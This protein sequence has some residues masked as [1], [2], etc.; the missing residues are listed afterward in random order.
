MVQ[1]KKRPLEASEWWDGLYSAWCIGNN[2]GTTNRVSAIV[3]PASNTSARPLG[4]VSGTKTGVQA[5]AS[6]KQHQQYGLTT[7][8]YT[9]QDYTRPAA[10]KPRDF[11]HYADVSPYIRRA[12]VELTDYTPVASFE[13]EGQ[14]LEILKDGRMWQTTAGGVIAKIPMDDKTFRLRTVGPEAQASLLSPRLLEWDRGLMPPASVILAWRNRLFTLC[15]GEAYLVIC[16]HREDKTKW[17]GVLPSQEASS[18]GVDTE[19]LDPSYAKAYEMGYESIGSTLHLHPG[20]MLCASSV[21]TDEWKKSGG[22]YFIAPRTLDKISVHVSVRNYVW[23]SVETIDLTGKPDDGTLSMLVGEEGQTTDKELAALIKPYRAVTHVAAS[24]T[25]WHGGTNYNSGNSYYC[26]GE[27]TSWGAA[28]ARS[29]MAVNA[30]EPQCL[31]D[32]KVVPPAKPTFPLLDFCEEE[33]AGKRADKWKEKLSRREEKK[34]KKAQKKAE[35]ASGKAYSAFEPAPHLPESEKAGMLKALINLVTAGQPADAQVGIVIEV[36]PSEKHPYVRFVKRVVSRQLAEKLVAAF[37]CG[38]VSIDSDILSADECKEES[39]AAMSA[40]EAKKL[41]DTRR[42]D[43]AQSAA[44]PSEADP[45]ME[46][47]H[48]M[49]EALEHAN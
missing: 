39:S 1:T 21:D 47:G 30:G 5:S 45:A 18:G 14:K 40:E 12:A 10:P 32:E 38:Q 11:E 3:T 37:P 24:N 48:R 35:K 17:L 8:S 7:T 13:Y 23:T 43:V 34:A 33:G 9:R 41:L 31:G 4:L 44:A 49:I 25:Q 22:V 26:R 27:L 36:P 16:R 2:L 29:W 42:K 46:A 15:T 19:D 20:A 28:E 6:R